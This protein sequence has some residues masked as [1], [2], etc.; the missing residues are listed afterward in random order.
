VI[1]FGRSFIIKEKSMGLR[2]LP[3]GVPFS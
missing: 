2:T 3:C 1:R